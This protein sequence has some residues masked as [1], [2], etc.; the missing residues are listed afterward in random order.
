MALAHASRRTRSWRLAG[1][2]TWLPRVVWPGLRQSTRRWR[3]HLI[4]FV[5]KLGPAFARMS[6]SSLIW[7]FS[8]RSAN[9]SARS[10]SWSLAGRSLSKGVAARAILT[11]LDILVSWQP[12]SLANSLGRRP[13]ATSST[14]CWRNSGGYGGFGLRGL[15]ISDSLFRNDKVSVKWGQ[16]QLHRG[17]EF[18]FHKV[19]YIN[20]LT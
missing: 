20:K 14:I 15:G 19:A 4:A 10:L 9:S 7:R 11:Q 2:C 12:N 18:S 1:H 8:L 6:R 13:A 3:G 5:C 17:R 16:L